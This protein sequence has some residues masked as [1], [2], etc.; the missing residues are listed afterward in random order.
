MKKIDTAAIAIELVGIVTVGTGIVT[1]VIGTVAVGAG[2][3]G[4]VTET[5]V[6]GAGIAI[7]VIETTGA[8]GLAIGKVEIE[9]IVGLRRRRATGRSTSASWRR[10]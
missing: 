1:A 8:A 3:A 6:D 4:A 10:K 2:I 5:A 9:T 7:A